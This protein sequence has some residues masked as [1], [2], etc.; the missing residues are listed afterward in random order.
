MKQFIFTVLSVIGLGL[1]AQ[2]QELS[3]MDGNYTVVGGHR[4]CSEL[5]FVQVQTE[6]NNVTINWKTKGMPDAIQDHYEGVNSNTPKVSNSIN[7]TIYEL[8]VFKAGTLKRQEKFFVFSPFESR[9]KDKEVILQM[10]SD[11]Q[12]VF[13]LKSYGDTFCQLQK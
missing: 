1:S 9:Y 6:S 12:V 4:Y 2:G 7:G 13:H 10:T 3:S 5:E 8:L 11:N